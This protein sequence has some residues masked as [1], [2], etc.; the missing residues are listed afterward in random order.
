MGWLPKARQIAWFRWPGKCFPS[1][2]GRTGRQAGGQTRKFTGDI[3]NHQDSP[4]VALLRGLGNKLLE[5]FFPPLQE[6]AKAI[7]EEAAIWCEIDRLLPDNGML[8]VKGLILSGPGE[9]IGAPAN[10][11]AADGSSQM[12]FVKGI[13]TELMSGGDLNA[14]MKDLR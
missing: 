5:P 9:Y 12:I 14:A 6:S 10:I 13:A 8:Y 2:R 11:V 1:T 7:V 3:N 4:I